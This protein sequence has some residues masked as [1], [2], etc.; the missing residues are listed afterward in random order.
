M[1]SIRVVY[2]YE[3]IDLLKAHGW[4][5]VCLPD[6]GCFFTRDENKKIPV[7]PHPS[8]PHLVYLADLQKHVPDELKAQLS[9]MAYDE[10]MI[11]ELFVKRMDTSV[12][13]A[14]S[15]FDALSTLDWV[16]GGEGLEFHKVPEMEVAQ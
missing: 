5:Y 10:D 4:T 12:D 11:F 9:K 7:C 16:F 6:Y 15:L 13:E 14:R 2:I 3:L 1:A 8:K